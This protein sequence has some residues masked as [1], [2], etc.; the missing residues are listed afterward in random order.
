[1]EKI[2]VVKQLDT[3]TMVHSTL[4]DAAITTVNKTSVVIYFSTW[5]AFIASSG[6]T[7]D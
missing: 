4:S 1:M 7:D 6:K 3:D 5:S 2:A